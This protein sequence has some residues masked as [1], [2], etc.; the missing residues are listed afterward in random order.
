MALN[1]DK[2]FGAFGESDTSSPT[3]GLNLS[4]WLIAIVSGVWLIPQLYR[5]HRTTSPKEK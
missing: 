5:V 4:W 2:R 3:I 1:L